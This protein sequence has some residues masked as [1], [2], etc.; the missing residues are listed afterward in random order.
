MFQEGS[1][2]FEEERSSVKALCPE[3]QKGNFRV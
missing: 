1:L 2:R 3:L